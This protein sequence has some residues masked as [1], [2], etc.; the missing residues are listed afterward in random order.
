MKKSVL[1]ILFVSS[2]VLLSACTTLNGIH[3]KLADMEMQK[4]QLADGSPVYIDFN[5]TP[6]ANWGCKEYGTLQSYNWQELQVQAQFHFTSNA[7]SML[8]D[9]ALAY[10]NQQNLK[11]NYLNLQIP[12]EKTFSTS[13]GNSTTSLVLNSDAQA[14]ASFYRCKLIN[15]E[16]NIGWEKKEDISVSVGK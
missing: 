15:P 6:T 4:R 9:N 10:A 14:V 12:T 5:S 13:S 8:M 11:L 2:T 16:H 7:H 3:D 1:S